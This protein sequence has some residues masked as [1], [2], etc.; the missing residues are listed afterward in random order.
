M[1]WLLHCWQQRGFLPHFT[2]SSRPFRLRSRWGAL[3]AA[4][5]NDKGCIRLP[6]ARTIDTKL[7]R[8][9][10]RDRGARTGD[11]LCFDLSAV[12]LMDGSRNTQSKDH[13]NCCLPWN[14]SKNKTKEQKPTNTSSDKKRDTMLT[15]RGVEQIEDQPLARTTTQSGEA[16]IR[17]C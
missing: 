7:W 3:I 8:A 10:A 17:E 9:I 13:Q 16:V 14:N 2:R 15:S 1:C 6:V 11:G 5:S 4:S 12:S